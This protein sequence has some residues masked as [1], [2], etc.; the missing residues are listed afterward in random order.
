MSALCVTHLAEASFKVK[1]AHVQRITILKVLCV[2]SVLL[3]VFTVIHSADVSAEVAF[4]GSMKNVSKL[5]RAPQ[6]LSITNPIRGASVM[7]G[8]SFPAQSVCL[9]I[10]VPK[11]QLGMGTLRNANATKAYI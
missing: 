5:Q 3:I 8:L 2:F 6:T 7:L 10:N 1:N 4:F 9:S 11:A